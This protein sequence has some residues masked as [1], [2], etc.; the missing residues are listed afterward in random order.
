MIVVVTVEKILLGPLCRPSLG[1]VLKLSRLTPPSHN[2]IRL[3]VVHRPTS[4]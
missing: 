4:T 1:G 2:W 3:R